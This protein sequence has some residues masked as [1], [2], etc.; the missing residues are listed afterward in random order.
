MA[1]KFKIGD[2]VVL[3]S[4]S[5]PMTVNA[6]NPNNEESIQVIW[7]DGKEVKKEFINEATAEI[8]E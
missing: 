4:G 2:V 7:H 1:N 8:Y 3:K 5:I 6:Y